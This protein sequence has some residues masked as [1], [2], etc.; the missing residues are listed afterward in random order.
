MK[1]LYSWA[2]RDPGDWE[3]CPAS[4]F[5][6]TPNRGAPAPVVLGQRPRGD[7]DNTPG[8]LSNLMVQ[9]VMFNG[10]DHVAVYDATIAGEDAVR[11]YGWNDD[12]ND[13]D[14][15]G[16]RVARIWTFLP[17]APDPTFGS[18]DRERL[19]DSIRNEP[20]ITEARR[21]EV[22]AWHHDPSHY[23]LNT[24]Q[25]QIVYAEGDRYDR[26]VAQGMPVLPWSVFEAD[27][28]QTIDPQ[29]TR[30][31]I[32]VPDEHWER[33]V[34]ARVPVG[35]QHW[36]E[37]LS[38]DECEWEVNEIRHNRQVR[39][40]RA[41]RR[42]LR[43]QRAQGRYS[44]ASHTIT[45]YQRDTARAVGFGAFEQELALEL[46]TAASGTVS[47]T[48]STNGI[49]VDEAVFTT[50][51]NEPNSADWPNGT[52]NTQV[53]VN[54]ISAGVTGAVSA[55]AAGGGASATGSNLRV[56][57][58]L[59]AISEDLDAGATA[60]TTT[61]LKLHSVVLNFAAGVASDRYTIRVVAK[62][63]S[64]GDAITLTLNTTDSYADGPWSTDPFPD[65]S[66]FRPRV[67]P[68]F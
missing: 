22:L 9:G 24:R 31:G 36:C 38:D 45:Y 50:P 34:E 4:E 14:Q 44:L 40:L 6:R 39:E 63:D 61:G 11:V 32:W 51:A 21:A 67:Q 52:F 20:G 49:F 58:D 41:P 13:P 15:T 18:G 59:S 16:G 68:F 64:H 66:G 42:V 19:L 1:V 29:R 65:S 27:I 25:S 12:P 43:E 23:P 62:G 35:W 37:H 57:S 55:K 56:T 5:H 60:F 17:L 48:T 7:N 54:A 26:M 2:Q 47:I 46:S 10:L 8:Y 28:L 33:Q 30:H 3:E 53:N